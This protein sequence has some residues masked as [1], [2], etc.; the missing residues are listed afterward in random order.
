MT[1]LL[2][3][4]DHDFRIPNVRGRQTAAFKA[5]MLL[6]VKRAWIDAIVATGAAVVPEV[7]TD[8]SPSEINAVSA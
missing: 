2:F 4:R 6:T 5:G 3:L 7:E 1:K 8:G